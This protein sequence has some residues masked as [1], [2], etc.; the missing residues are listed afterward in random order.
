MKPKKGMLLAS[1]TLK[2][3]IGVICI[4]FLVYLLMSLYY[5]KID[6]QNKEY[7]QSLID[8][9]NA[10]LPTLNSEKPTES[11]TDIKP[12]G[13]YIYSFVEGEKK[14]NQCIDK[15][16]VCICDDVYEFEFL[17]SDKQIKEC[18]ENGVCQI[19]TNLMKFEPIEIVK[20]SKGATSIELFV[21]GNF[22]GVRKK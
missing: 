13:W 12:A 16:C 9:I 8:R 3:I 20:H 21:Q 14:P 17:F 7:A 6:G 10:I 19:V 18:S 15:S 2:I 4:G 11:I 5:S 1:E 22:V